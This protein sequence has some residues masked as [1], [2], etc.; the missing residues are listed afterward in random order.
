MATRI[1]RDHFAYEPDELPEARN[2]AAPGNIEVSEGGDVERGHR[3]DDCDCERPRAPVGD[4]E[5]R[6]ARFDCA[7]VDRLGVH[8][9]CPFES[10]ARRR[11]WV[12]MS[13]VITTAMIITRMALT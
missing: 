8:A 6:V 12:E 7:D 9:S 1:G 11:Y 4:E 3:P 10:S 13:I 2:Q 5:S